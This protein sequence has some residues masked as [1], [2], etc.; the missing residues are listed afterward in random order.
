[1]NT[2]LCSLGNFFCQSMLAIILQELR[3]LAISRSV[4]IDQLESGVQESISAVTVSSSPY[5]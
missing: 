1:M 3:K 4:N 2:C 5:I